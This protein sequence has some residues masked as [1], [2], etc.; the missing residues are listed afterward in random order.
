M[1]VRA[2]FVSWD[3]EKHPPHLSAHGAFYYAFTADGDR[4]NV[5]TGYSLS[6]Y[7]IRNWNEPP[8]SPPP[9]S[10]PPVH[11]LAICPAVGCSAEVDPIP[12]LPK[13]VSLLYIQVHNKA[14]QAPGRAI[15]VAVSRLKLK[16]ESSKIKVESSNKLKVESFSEPQC[17]EAEQPRCER[18]SQGVNDEDK[19]ED[20]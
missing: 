15:S 20:N 5:A 2:P 12:L 18:S 6:V 10:S 13:V 1:I 19:D 17:A 4:V 16:V 11:Y 7:C 9:S 8:S 3:P 14:L